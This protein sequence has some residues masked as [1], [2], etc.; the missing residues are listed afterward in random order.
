MKSALCAV[1]VLV[2]GLFVTPAM[3]DCGVGVFGSHGVT[4]QV[5]G[6]H[7]VGVPVVQFAP[8]VP[9]VTHTQPI[10]VNAFGARVDP[11]VFHQRSRID[12]RSRDARFES[13]KVRDRG[14][15]ESVRIRSR[16]RSR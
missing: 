8:A 1:A 10:V 14:N 7:V 6:A 3:A 9:F 15:V 5:A 16:S 11:F 2:G 13:F 4:V 12:V